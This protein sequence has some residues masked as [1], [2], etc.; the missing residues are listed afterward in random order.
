MCMRMYMHAPL[1]FIYSMAMLWRKYTY[2]KFSKRS[3]LTQLHQGR[4]LNTKLG[5]EHWQIPYTC[6][7]KN[8]LGKAAHTLTHTFLGKHAN[9]LFTNTKP[10][11]SV[12]ACELKGLTNCMYIHTTTWFIFFSNTT[13]VPTTSNS[14][15]IKVIKWIPLNGATS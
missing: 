14:T 4:L 10:P 2:N 9:H 13:I 5:S 12:M 11:T 8:Y 3:L 1:S 15:C 7:L 6:S